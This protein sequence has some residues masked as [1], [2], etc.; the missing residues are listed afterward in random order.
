[1][2]LTQQAIKLWETADMVS[3]HKEWGWDNMPARKRFHFLSFRQAMVCTYLEEKNKTQGK[4]VNRLPL[5][6][7]VLAVEKER[8][9]RR[10]ELYIQSGFKW[11]LGLTYLLFQ[12]RS[13]KSLRAPWSPMVAWHAKNYKTT[14]GVY[15]PE[16]R[17]YWLGDICPLTCPLLSCISAWP[18]RLH[19]RVNGKCCVH[20]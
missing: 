15:I 2:V 10:W 7:N 18:A 5:F 14:K 4:S 19:T 6:I 13:F 11:S 9:G 12:R 20:L 16:E 1:M 17:G 8:R 3:Q